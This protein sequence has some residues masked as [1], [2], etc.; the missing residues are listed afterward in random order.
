MHMAP[1][2]DPCDGELDVVTIGDVGRLRFVLNLPRV[3]R[4]SHVDGETVKSWRTTSVE[5]RAARELTVYADGDPLTT[6]P[7]R[8]RILPAALIVLVPGESP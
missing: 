6:L 8:V 1:N 7:A 5:I 2:A 4:G 3:F